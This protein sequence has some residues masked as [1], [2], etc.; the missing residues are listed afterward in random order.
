MNLTSLNDKQKQAVTAGDGPMLIL[1]GAGSG[2]TKVLTERVAYLVEQMGVHPLSI[3][4]ITFTNKAAAEM[5]ERIQKA[6]DMDVKDMWISTF[7]SMCVRI[8]RISGKRIGYG[9]N[10]V[11]YDT[12]DSLRL[13][14]QILE[15]LALRMIKIIHPR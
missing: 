7:H 3:L 14:K 1:A 8:L 6:L 13:L 4:S 2:K 11:I 10:F 9:S 12:D 15:D 5:R